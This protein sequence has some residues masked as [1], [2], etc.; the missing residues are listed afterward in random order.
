MFST[1][2]DATQQFGSLFDNPVRK[3]SR[4]VKNS[5][6]NR[7]D[8]HMTSLKRRVRKVDMTL[9]NIQGWEEF[10]FRFFSRLA[11]NETCTTTTEYSR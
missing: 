5:T 10:I 7:A 8:D 2:I 6:A 1:G 3:D 4:F 9:C 11:T